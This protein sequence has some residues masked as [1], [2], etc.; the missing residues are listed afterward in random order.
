MGKLVELSK[1]EL[2]TSRVNVI[3]NLLESNKPIIIEVPSDKIAVLVRLGEKVSLSVTE[4]VDSRTKY[5]KSD[6]SN[7]E[8]VPISAQVLDKV[9]YIEL[10]IG[11]VRCLTNQ[12]RCKISRAV[13]YYEKN[14]SGKLR[15]NDLSN[16]H[17]KFLSRNLKIMSGQ[18]RSRDL[19]SDYLLKEEVI[20]FSDRSVG[21]LYNGI[22]VN[23]K[24]E[25]LTIDLDSVFVFE[26]DIRDFI[27]NPQNLIEEDSPY[28]IPVSLRG[29]SDLDKLAEIA[30]NTFGYSADAKAKSSDLARKISA[31]MGYKEKKAAA[32]AFY[33]QPNPRGRKV[34]D[35]AAKKFNLVK[36]LAPNCQFPCLIYA[37]ETFVLKQPGVDRNSLTEDIVNFLEGVGMS[38]DNAKYGEIFIRSKK[39]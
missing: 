37:L 7:E 21:N 5:P 19:Y 17:L 15:F 16:K 26:N 18:R 22:D 10:P 38:A 1:V 3:A 12:G 27:A 28:Y 24:A 6:S 33:L 13:R 25:M 35:E 34:K 14:D 39:F 23:F 11:D 29:M 4:R 30:I 9:E 8:L 31:I 2:N 32:A 36:P 20:L